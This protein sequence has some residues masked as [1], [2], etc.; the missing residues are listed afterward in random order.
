MLDERIRQQI[1]KVRNEIACW[2]YYAI[3]ISFLVKELVFAV[4]LQDCILEF[5]LMIAVPVYQFVRFRMLEVNVDYHKGN[6]WIIGLLA[7]IVTASAVY[8]YMTWRQGNAVQAGDII[9]NAIAFAAAFCGIRY[10]LTRWTQRQN[11]KMAEKYD[12][13]EES[14]K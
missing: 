2:M 4:P 3:V 9:V 11:E 8:A 10:F 1:F 7:S 6:C 5:V 14:E 13:E 12:D